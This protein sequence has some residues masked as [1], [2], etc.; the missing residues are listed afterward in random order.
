MSCLS[1]TIVLYC[2]HWLWSCR[3][4]PAEAVVRRLQMEEGAGAVLPSQGSWGGPGG[5]RAASRSGSRSPTRSSRREGHMSSAA[6]SARAL[7]KAGVPER[8]PA[9]ED[10]TSVR[11]A[12]TSKLWHD[13]PHCDETKTKAAVISAVRLFCMR[14]HTIQQD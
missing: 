11:S 4:G 5:S 12:H 10:V 14:T 9:P 8:L 2:E 13:I 6:A 1:L 7:G 3:Q